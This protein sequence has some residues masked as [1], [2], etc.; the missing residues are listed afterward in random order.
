[1]VILS[2][3]LSV[4]AEAG[5]VAFPLHIIS[6]KIDSLLGSVNSNLADAVQGLEEGLAAAADSDDDDDDAAAASSSDES[7]MVSWHVQGGYELISIL[8]RLLQACNKESTEAAH[9]AIAIM[10]VEIKEWCNGPGKTK[11]GDGNTTI[12]VKKSVLL[13]DIMNDTLENFAAEKPKDPVSADELTLIL[14]TKRWE[15]V[16]SLEPGSECFCGGSGDDDGGG[17]GANTELLLFLKCS[18]CFHEECIL[19]WFAK[20]STCPTCRKPAEA[21]PLPPTPPHNVGASAAG[22]DDDVPTTML[23]PVAACKGNLQKQK[24][25]RNRSESVEGGGGDGDDDDIEGLDSKRQCV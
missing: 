11:Y 23:T 16:K 3:M 10:A 19:P 20:E 24:R 18:H 5:T 25:K 6:E 17:G 8:N 7:E 9:L 1:M 12:N 21:A 13:G 2:N 15:N 14:G 22:D 4:S